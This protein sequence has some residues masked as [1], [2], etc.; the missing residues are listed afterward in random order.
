[1]DEL[2]LECSSK[3]DLENSFVPLPKKRK[4]KMASSSDI[5]FIFQNMFEFGNIEGRPW[6][7][8]PAYLPS[9]VTGW[10]SSETGCWTR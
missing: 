7:M 9:N 5:T 6:P 3:L 10:P 2:F 4:E 1:M 8:C